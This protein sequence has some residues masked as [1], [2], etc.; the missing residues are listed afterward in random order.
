MIEILHRLRLPLEAF[1][2]EVDATSLKARFN[3]DT[4]VSI[5]HQLQE[6]A[7]EKLRSTLYRLSHTV[8]PGLASA[9]D[10]LEVEATSTSSSSNA[11]ANAN[12]NNNPNT[13]H[14]SGSRTISSWRHSAC[15]LRIDW[16]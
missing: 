3:I 1:R 9:L 10:E 16:S 4:F 7:A 5:R 15:V 8:T 2:N 13:Y 14:N 11:I 12:P 6:R